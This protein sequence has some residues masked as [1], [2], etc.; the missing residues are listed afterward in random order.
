MI[1][2]AYK[3]YCSKRDAGNTMQSI[4]KTLSECMFPKHALPKRARKNKTQ[5]AKTQVLKQVRFGNLCKNNERMR[6]DLVDSSSSSSSS[7]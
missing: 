3:R 4:L 6:E 7:K 1:V 5:N 2:I